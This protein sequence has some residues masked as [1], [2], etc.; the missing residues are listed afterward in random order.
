MTER[1]FNLTREP[2]I[3]ALNQDGQMESVS[4]LD[5]FKQAHQ[6]RA[7][8]GE[9]VTQN[10]AMMRLLIA[11]LY[12]VFGREDLEGNEGVPQT[13]R[14]ARARWQALWERGSFP[15]EQIE[16]YLNHFEN[17]FFLFDPQRPFFQVVVPPETTIET[18]DKQGN[19]IFLPAYDYTKKLSY[20]IGDL[21][22]GE[23]KPRWF[24][25]R[26]NRSDVSYPEAARWLVHLNSFDVAPVGAP[27]GGYFQPKA[28]GL[29]W[30]NTLGLVWA[31]GDTLFET[32]MLNLV[33]APAGQDLWAD[34][35]PSWEEEPFVPDD[36]KQI[37]KPFPQDPCALFSFLYR[38]MQ[39]MRDDEKRITGIIM[40]GGHKLDGTKGNPLLET[41]TV[42]KKDKGIHKPK[43]HNPERQMWRDL[44][45]ILPASPDDTA[46]GIVS[47]LSQLKREKQLR[48]PL[49]RLA[50]AGVVLGKS[51]ALVDNSF[52]DSLRFNLALL[53]DAEEGHAA[54]AN[55]EIALADKMVTAVANFAR[56]LVQAAGGSGDQTIREA[57][58][59]ARTQAY[60]R[61]DSPFRNWLG[62]LEEDTDLDE[63]CRTWRQTEVRLLLDLAEG[64]VQQAGAK[65]LVGRS[66]KLRPQ[67]AKETILASPKLFAA[68]SGRLHK[69]TKE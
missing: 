17:R 30:P 60:F 1:E 22:E 24:V 36:L 12:A 61:L 45:A 25:Y 19:T 42:W 63:A 38:R 6:L 46:P 62:S 69:L 43:S 5:L 23:N 11:I 64:M 53:Q 47:W 2:W 51:N 33:L 39:L 54:R 35:S 29:P 9:M 41:M 58:V 40:W 18:K 8:A 10:V 55:R 20:F 59:S 37:E 56:G 66:V 67:D 49:L 28:Y 48:L 68:L 26:T 34:F 32:L 7:L 3:L 50:I 44:S 4:L 13:D 15:A 31:E 65:A 27:K 16:E 52:S 57:V 14:D 21:S